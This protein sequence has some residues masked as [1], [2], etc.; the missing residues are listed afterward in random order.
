[1]LKFLVLNSPGFH[2]RQADLAI[3]LSFSSYCRRQQVYAA[4]SAGCLESA[5]SDTK[6]RCTYLFVSINPLVGHLR[7]DKTH[8]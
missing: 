2:L 4:V 6:V 1:M 7:T 5:K 3:T 8:L